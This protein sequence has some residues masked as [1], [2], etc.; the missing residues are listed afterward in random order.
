[1]ITVYYDGKCGLCA[2][3]INHYK[4]IA[5]KGL[6]QWQDVTESM[7]GMEKHNISL[8][9][10]LKRIH[11]E[12]T[13]GKLFSG[14]GAFLLIWTQLSFKWRFLAF[15]LALPLI[16]QIADLTYIGFAYWRFKNLNHCQIALK[17]E[18]QS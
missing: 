5:P 7:D 12:N 2:K 10:A 17:E 16:R 9:R 13:A 11:A 6:F 3:E 8:V 15:L 1:M 18:Q 14:V 4:T